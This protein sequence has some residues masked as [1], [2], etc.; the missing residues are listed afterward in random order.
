M[1]TTRFIGNA[2]AVTEVQTIA[3]TAYDASTT[4][5]IRRNGK[6]VSVSGGG[7]STAVA[8]ALVAALETSEF[9]EFTEFTATSSTDTITLTGTIPGKPFTV[10]TAVSGGTGTIGNPSVTT[11]AT[12]P[13]HWNDL[14]NWSGGA[15][16]VDG[17]DV[18]IE[19]LASDILYGL[20]QSSVTLAS[21]TLNETFTGNLGLPVMTDDAVP[22]AEDRDTYLR[23]SATALNIDCQS[24]RIKI[25]TG[26]AQTTINVQQ[27]GTSTETNTPAFLWKGTH[28]SNVLNVN[29]GSVGVAFLGAEVATV[30]TLRVGYQTDIAGDSDVWCGAGVT[31]TT[32]EKSGGRLVTRSAATTI[33]QTDGEL[34]TYGGAIT[35]INLDGGDLYHQSTG[36]ISTL[37]VGGDA[38]ADFSRDMRGRTVTQC[39]LYKDSTLHDPAKTVTWSNPIDLIRCRLSEVTIDLGV[40]MSIQPGAI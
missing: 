27:T 16:P 4:Y 20:N 17:D 15:V 36:T 26:T 19:H 34:T 25:D 23:I 18:I 28:A 6:S 21:M 30:A 5:S 32:I 11:A 38:R 1:A 2:G 8:A 13:S 12:G 24:G 7:T 31:L 29:R 37:N 39:N 35:T 10:T 22:Y 40:H 3:V 9:T 33:T 14:N